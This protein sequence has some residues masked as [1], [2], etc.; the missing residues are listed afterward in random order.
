MGCGTLGLGCL[1]LYTR[2]CVL[3]CVCMNLFMRVCVQSWRKSQ[4]Y[5]SMHVCMYVCI[6]VCTHGCIFLY[7]CALHTCTFSHGLVALHVCSYLSLSLS[8]DLSIIQDVSMADYT[9]CWLACAHVTRRYYIILRMHHGP[10]CL[11]S[12]HLGSWQRPM[13][14][15]THKE[16]SKIKVPNHLPNRLCF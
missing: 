7:I 4:E 5:V 10:W 6:Y 2:V 11:F 15:D 8:R 13:H 3:L 12:V 9:A 1:D 16:K 14:R